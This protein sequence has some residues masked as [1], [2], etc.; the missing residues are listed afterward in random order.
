LSSSI[1]STADALTAA[2]AAA[3][4]AKVGGLGVA[5]TKANSVGYC[6]AARFQSLDT[7]IG[8]LLPLDTHTGMLLP[9]S[10]TKVLFCQT[11]LQ[12]L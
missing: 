1:P 12:A 2:A 3:A 5:E 9:E 11:V 6:A 10:S 8:M 4:A 7:H